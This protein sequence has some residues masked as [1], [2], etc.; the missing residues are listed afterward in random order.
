MF[1]AALVLRAVDNGLI[2]LDEPMPAIAGVEPPTRAVTVRQLL[3]HTSGL[4]DYTESPD[5][6]GDEYLTPIEAVNLSTRVAQRT[7]PGRTVHYANTNF[8]YL[9]LLLEQRTR[10]A[11][12]DQ[13]ER[14]MAELGLKET[15]VV[16]PDRPGWTAGGAGGIVSTVA[17]LAEWSSALFTPG[18]VLSAHAIELMTALDVHNVGLGTWPICPCWT[19]DQNQKHYTA[20]GHHFGSGAVEYYPVTGISVAGRI[21]PTSD[22]A[23]GQ[24]ADLG[25]QYQKLLTRLRAA[26]AAPVTTPSTTPSAAAPDT[27]ITSSSTPATTALGPADGVG[28]VSPR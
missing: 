10:V 26:A 23:G 28:P 15:S 8:L 17:D 9:Q 7:R 5:F 12:A 27:T 13:I 2:S 25:V 4:I 24:A 19:D 11:Y 18:R 16:Q 22:A 6:H 1:T 20:I 3:T 14:L 21:D